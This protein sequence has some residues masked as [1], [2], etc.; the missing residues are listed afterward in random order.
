LQQDPVNDAEDGGGGADA[1][2]QR[3]HRRQRE[4]GPADQRADGEAEVVAE[5]V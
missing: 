1:E 4:A 2:R 5:A 3:G